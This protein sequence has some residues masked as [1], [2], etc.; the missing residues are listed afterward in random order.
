MLGKAQHGIG[1]EGEG[2]QHIRA[3]VSVCVCGCLW[4]SVGLQ[5]TV[6]APAGPSGH[7]VRE[8][9]HGHRTRGHV[10]HGV[11]AGGLRTRTDTQNGHANG[12]RRVGLEEIKLKEI[13][14]E[15]TLPFAGALE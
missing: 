14:G 7:V 2:P 12:V 9:A 8:A 13:R 15:S 11:A 4:E 5:R 10:H 1:R 3:M 6:H